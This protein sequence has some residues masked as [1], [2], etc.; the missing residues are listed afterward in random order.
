MP[1]PRTTR[2]RLVLAFAV[3]AISPAI[4]E[5]IDPQNDGS[6]YAWG[7]NVGWLNAEPG[8]DG[9]NGIAVTDSGLSGWLWGENIGWISLSCA[10]TGSC[11][12]VDY[13]ITNDGGTLAGLAWAENLGWVSFSC[14]T[15][16]SCGTAAHGVTI[17]P[18]T[19][20]FSGEAWGE[21][22]GWIRFSS[23]GPVPFRVQTAWSCAPPSGAVSLLIGPA[24]TGVD[25]SWPAVPGAT[26]YDVVRGD[27]G[28]LRSSSGDFSIAVTDCL[29]NDQGGLIYNATN[30]PDPGQALFYLVRAEACLAGTYDTAGPGQSA[31]RDAEVA[32]APSAC[33]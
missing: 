31:P 6:Q 4:A 17:D 30:D 12:T 21:N 22:V 24:I 19:G 5:N 7:E 15:T 14:A 10:N 9:G 32:L 33:P 27:L 23:V 28:L 1:R 2:R 13:G 3:A 29:S 25:L 20:V 8:G 16:A 11:G 18:L 26:S